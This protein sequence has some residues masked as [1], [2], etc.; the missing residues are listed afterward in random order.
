MFSMENGD[1][2]PASSRWFSAQELDEARIVGVGNTVQKWL[3][4]S[5]RSSP[6]RR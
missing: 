6:K 5:T 2:L 4:A 3:R 1:W